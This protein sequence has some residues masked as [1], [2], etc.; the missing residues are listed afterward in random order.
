MTCRELAELL[1]DHIAGE[2]AAEQEAA[3]RSHLDACPE[4]VH[5][6]A[7]YQLTIQITRRLPCTPCPE[8]VWEKLRRAIEEENQP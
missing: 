8:R 4:C 5:Y 3:L 2:L 7:T 1:I 6:V